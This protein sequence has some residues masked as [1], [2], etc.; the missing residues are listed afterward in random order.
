[1]R[2][3][4]LFICSFILAAFFSVSAQNKWEADTSSQATTVVGV[5]TYGREG[6]VAAAAANGV[7]AFIESYNGTK[8]TRTAVQAGLLMDAAISKSGASV[9]TSMLQV[10]YSTDGKTYSVAPVQGVSQAAYIFGDNKDS[11]AL[12]GTWMVKDTKVP[13]SVA[14]VATSRDKG[15]TWELS[16]NVPVGYVR[17][18]AFPSEQTWYISSGMWGEDPVV[19]GKQLSAW[20]SMDTKNSKFVVAD[21]SSKKRSTAEQTGWFGAVSKTTDGGKT[22]TQ[23]FSSNLETDYYYFNGI[24]CSNVDHCTVVGEGDDVNGGYLNVAFTTFDG[25][26]TWERVLSAADVSMMSVDYLNDNEGW[27]IGSR[28]AG[29]KLSAVL[30]RT[31]DG[32]KTFL[33]HETFDDCLATDLDFADDGTAAA[34]CATSS[35]AS[36]YVALYH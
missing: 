5:G 14:G 36:M 34:A 6:V 3:F 2:R 21:R 11:F 30:Y 4:A 32:G 31:T 9:A 20:L 13:T 29:R 18:G 19:E 24:A 28:K 35:G 23:V 16:S 8:W 7:G 10:F 1:M 26:V 33:E 15:T 25:G 27:L 12:V 17:Y 22:W